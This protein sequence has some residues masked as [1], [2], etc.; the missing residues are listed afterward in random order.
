MKLIVDI[1]FTARVKKLV[2]VWKTCLSA[3]KRLY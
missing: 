1:M 2:T 3:P